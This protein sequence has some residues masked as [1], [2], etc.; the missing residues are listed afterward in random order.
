MGQFQSG[1][2]RVRGVAETRDSGFRSWWKEFK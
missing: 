2:L 1:S